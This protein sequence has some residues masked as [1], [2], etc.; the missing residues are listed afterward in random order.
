MASARVP[1]VDYL[2]LEP[3][4]HL[5]A[6]ECR[7][8]GARFFD[9]RNACA[10]CGT[11]DFDTAPVDNSGELQSFTIVHRA[12]PGIPVPFVSTIVKT[13]DGTWVRSNLVNCDPTPEVVKLGMRVRLTTYP[14]GADDDGTEAVAFG[15]E[16][17]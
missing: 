15:Y 2:Q 10:R 8:C 3:E 6:Q 4:P 14:V 1:L 9:R 17:T 11:T 5:V 12:A 16:P 13:D 7:I